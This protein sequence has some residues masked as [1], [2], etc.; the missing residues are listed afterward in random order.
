MAC[1]LPLST[2]STCLFLV[3]ALRL[4]LS[5][6]IA[7]EPGPWQ[8]HDFFIVLIQVEMGFKVFGHKNIEPKLETFHIN[9][10]FNLWW[11]SIGG[12][13]DASERREKLKTFN[14]EK[15]FE[16]QYYTCLR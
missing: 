10:Y 13:V 15:F 11:Y 9:S 14:Q 3:Y 8:F 7:V 12:P 6:K 16:A 2:S 1:H 5:L 4:S